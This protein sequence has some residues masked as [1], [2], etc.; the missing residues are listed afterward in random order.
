MTTMTT[1]AVPVS[2]DTAT[3]H[4]LMTVREWA[5]GVPGLESAFGASDFAEWADDA[6]QLSTG[7]FAIASEAL[8]LTGDF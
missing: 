8:R 4:R 2:R 6:R 7:S 5:A 3:A 1:A